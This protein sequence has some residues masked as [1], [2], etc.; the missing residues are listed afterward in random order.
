MAVEL[1]A[2]IENLDKKLQMDVETKISK[3]HTSH[4]FINDYERTSIISLRFT[5]LLNG[6]QTTLAPDVFQQC[7]SYKEVAEK[8][9][10]LKIIPLKVRR[11]ISPTQI[12]DWCLKD[13]K[14]L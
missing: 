13:F 5:H 9:Y 3:T 6:C 2:K 14:Q 4:P 8:E 1:N 12:E 7:S 11:H 10:E